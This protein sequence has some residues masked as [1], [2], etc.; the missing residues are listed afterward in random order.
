MACLVGWNTLQPGFWGHVGSVLSDGLRQIVLDKEGGDLDGFSLVNNRTA[1]HQPVGGGLASKGIS[2]HVAVDLALGCHR[3]TDE[4]ILVI[5][6][7]IR[8]SCIDGR[9]SVPAVSTHE[10]AENDLEGA[11]VMGKHIAPGV[12]VQQDELG[13][14]QVDQFR[15]LLLLNTIPRAKLAQHGDSLRRQLPDGS[16]HVYTC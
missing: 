11:L 12:P 14:A 13:C 4:T 1:V 3:D 6:Q 7:R 15:H 10:P 8:I 9:L 5:M 2:I 16:L